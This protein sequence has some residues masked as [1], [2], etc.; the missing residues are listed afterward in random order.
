MYAIEVTKRSIKQKTMEINL[1]IHSIIPSEKLYFQL[2]FSAWNDV[3]KARW[4]S[5]RP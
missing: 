4:D 2:T 1:N 5:C 3:I